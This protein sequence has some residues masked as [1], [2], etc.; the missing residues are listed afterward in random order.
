[1]FRRSSAVV[2]RQTMRGATATATTTTTSSAVTMS[3]IACAAPVCGAAARAHASRLASSSTTS[4]SAPSSAMPRP[5]ST[6]GF[7]SSAASGSKAV[8]VDVD[9][10]DIVRTLPEYHACD[11]LNAEFNFVRDEAMVKDAPNARATST[12]GG[13]AAAKGKAKAAAS[14]AAAPKK[15]LLVRGVD[16][17][18]EEALMSSTTRRI[19]VRG[20]RGT[21]KS[22]AL[23]RAVMSA[24][25][26]GAVVAYVPDGLE[27]T[28]L[29]YFSKSANEDGMWDTPDC[30]MRFLK[31]VANSANESVLSAI[32]VPKMSMKELTATSAK[33]KATKKA[34]G[35][36][37]KDDEAASV[38]SDASEKVNMFQY[39]TIASTEP[40][41]A[42]DCAIQV[43]HALTTLAK[44]SDVKVVFVVDQY[45][46]LHGPSDMF[47]VTG[48]RSKKNIP[49]QNLR[50]V[51]ALTQAIESSTLPDAKHVAVTAASE[52]IGVSNANTAKS[53]PDASN[54]DL[55]TVVDCPK[56]SIDEI[57]AMLREY[58]RAGVL[59]AS[60]DEKTVEGMKA[61]TNGN[62]REMQYV[63]L[64]TLR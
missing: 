28:R 42:I 2:A 23:A 43:I 24:R 45:N 44:T 18:L 34:K 17:A 37:S 5:S 52:T 25:A 29:S 59:Y 13:D 9:D 38:S 15:R 1:M 48:P 40:S 56:Y 14:P 12:S 4:S 30:A 55:V 8:F 10:D 6:R 39:A 60:V 31:H 20:S 36:D 51:R 41:L 50:I 53:R 64:A 26:K 47:E 27:L 16:S 33:K 63:A 7:A 35:K 46:A 3:S 32:D 19:D 58:K 62:P 61:L 57:D 54:T 22:V 49:A 21:G 11:G